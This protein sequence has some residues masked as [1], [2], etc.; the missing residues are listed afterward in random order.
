[1]RGF[2]G[3]PPPAARR[4]DCVRVVA[5]KDIG[6]AGERL[7]I[8]GFEAV[9]Q[10][11]HRS[12]VRVLGVMGQPDRLHPGIAVARRTVRQ[13]RGLLV[14][15]QRRIEVFDP[16]GRSS[17]YDHSMTLRAGSLEELRQG[18]FQRHRQ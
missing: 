8:L 1:V 3:T 13:E 7:E 11:D 9:D 4:L 5:V 6:A 2:A 17:P 15:P 10:N 14:R 18:P 12:A 16:L